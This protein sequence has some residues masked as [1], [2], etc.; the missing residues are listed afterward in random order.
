MHPVDGHVIL[1][2]HP[3]KP[4]ALN[5]QVNAVD[6]SSIRTISIRE[7]THKVKRSGMT[8]ADTYDFIGQ[9]E[10]MLPLFIAAIL[11]EKER[12]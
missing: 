8:G 1:P 11:L 4:A 7:R 10:Q 6:F 12:L 9:H 3:E 5:H 2:Q